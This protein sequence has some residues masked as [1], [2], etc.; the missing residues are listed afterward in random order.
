MLPSV[1]WYQR[2]QA[3]TPTSLRPVA[4]LFQHSAGSQFDPVFAGWQWEAV[5]RL[6]LLLREK[7]FAILRNFILRLTAV[8]VLVPN[9]AW[10]A[11]VVHSMVGALAQDGVACAAAVH[12][13][14]I[15]LVNK[16]GGH[17]GISQPAAGA[18]GRGAAL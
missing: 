12:S 10:T 14:Y 1:L 16:G 7:L 18:V 6:F 2:H 4:G 8:V 5:L 17:Y 11:P 3:N 9:L 13:T 15:P